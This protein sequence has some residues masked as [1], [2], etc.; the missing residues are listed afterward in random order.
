MSLLARFTL[1]RARRHDARAEVFGAACAAATLAGDRQAAA[2]FLE[3]MHRAQALRD[4]LLA[5]VSDG[6]DPTDFSTT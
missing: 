1:Y 4:R 3:Q 2:E 5:R 6:F